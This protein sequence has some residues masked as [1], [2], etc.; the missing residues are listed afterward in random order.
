MLSLLL[1]LI[2]AM[3]D[4]EL[5]SDNHWLYTKETLQVISIALAESRRLGHNFLGSEQLLSSSTTNELIQTQSGKIE[6]LQPQNF[7]HITSL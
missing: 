5:S 3:S 6:L 7:T 2:D 1:T 4:P